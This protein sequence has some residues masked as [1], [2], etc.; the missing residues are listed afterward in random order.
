M[1]RFQFCAHLTLGIISFFLVGHVSKE[2]YNS[3]HCFFLNNYLFSRFYY[4]LHVSL[5]LACAKQA[6]FFSQLCP[7]SVNGM[8]V[9]K[10]LM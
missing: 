10:V 4:K 5:G 6:N 7:A 1:A 3:N 2:K 9:V 8:Q